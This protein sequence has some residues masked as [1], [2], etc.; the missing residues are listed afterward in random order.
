M[1]NID[2]ALF[3]LSNIASFLIGGYFYFKEGT[4]IGYKQ[5]SKDE[6][7]LMG[8]SIARAFKPDEKEALDKVSTEYR[9]LQVEVDQEL[10]KVMDNK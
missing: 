4:R 10:Q 1:S 5:G 6:M 7:M 9:R 8:V 2:L 3:L